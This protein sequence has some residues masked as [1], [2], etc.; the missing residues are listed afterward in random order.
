MT[1]AQS[2]R[3]RGRDYDPGTAEALADPLYP[4]PHRLPDKNLA[5]SVLSGAY[6][7]AVLRNDSNSM[8]NSKDFLQIA[9][10]KDF[11]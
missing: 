11:V 6:V 2:K 1:Y 8:W 10:S 9:E 4:I 5:T 3:Y 7:V